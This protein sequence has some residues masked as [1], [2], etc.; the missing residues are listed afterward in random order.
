MPY[1][2][3]VAWQ[4]CH[5]LALLTYKVTQRF[6]KSELYGITSQMRRAAASAAATIAEGASKR[7]QPEFRRFLD[8]ALGSLSELKY[9][10]LLAKDLNLLPHDEWQEFESVSA[11]AGK[12]TMG[13]YK[14]VARR[15]TTTRRAVSSGSLSV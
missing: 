7:G 5:R 8:M 14:A 3:F 13:L 15:V 9:F 4:H 11:E 10:G 1:E 12:T 6:P 2:K